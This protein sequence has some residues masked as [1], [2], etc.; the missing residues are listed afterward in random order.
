MIGCDHCGELAGP[1]DHNPGCP[2][3]PG[4]TFATRLLE[5]I[6]AEADL[7]GWTG[8]PVP[9]SAA[10]T[11]EWRM[12]RLGVPQEAIVN[13][14]APWKTRAREAAE[15]FASAPHAQDRFLLLAGD[16]GLGKSVAAAWLLRQQLQDGQPGCFWVPA[17]A[18]TSMSAYEGEPERLERVAFLVLDDLGREPKGFARDLLSGV[19]MRRYEQLRRTVLTTNAPADEVQALYGPAL[20]DRIRTGMVVSLDGPSMRRAEGA[21]AGGGER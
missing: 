17:T 10:A 13:L 12:K 3:A 16:K 2:A 21:R 9:G 1:H 14:R 8:A 18:F 15:A 5:R 7:K 11:L 19:L 6:K 20:W 4:R